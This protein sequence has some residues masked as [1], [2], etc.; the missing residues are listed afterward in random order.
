MPRR[1]R[2]KDSIEGKRSLRAAVYSELREQ[3]ELETIA[4]YRKLLRP[5]GKSFEGATHH[6]IDYDRICFDARDV[7][8]SKD[9]WSQHIDSS[10]IIGPMIN[11]GAS[12]LR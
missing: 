4:I 8:V 11:V 1:Y 2:A 9:K 5:S 3:Q 10:S 6:I 7:W 12:F